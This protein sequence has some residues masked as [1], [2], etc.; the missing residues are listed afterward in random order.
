MIKVSHVMN[1]KVA[2]MR[3][4]TIPFAGLVPIIFKT[5]N[6]KKTTNI[7]NL[8]SGMLIFLNI[9]MICKSIFSRLFCTVIYR[10]I[11]PSLRSYKK[12]TRYAPI[13]MIAI[14]INEYVSLETPFSMSY[15]IFGKKT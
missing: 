3:S 11:L 15:M 5:P 4:C 10:L 7:E 14:P 12:N 6:Q 8:A 9:C 2:R 1:G 13:A